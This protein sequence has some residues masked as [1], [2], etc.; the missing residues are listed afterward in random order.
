MHTSRGR[1]LRNTGGRKGKKNKVGND[2]S[3]SLQ[4]RVGLEDER[5]H[6][7][8]R[9]RKRGKGSAVVVVVIIRVCARAR[10]VSLRT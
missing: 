10:V 2:K 5:D 1:E 6:F 4:L 8:A 9:L 7:D 3:A